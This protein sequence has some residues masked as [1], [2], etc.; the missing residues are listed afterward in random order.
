MNL[1]EL[2]CEYCLATEK[3]KDLKKWFEFVDEFW[4]KHDTCMDFRYIYSTKM[5]KLKGGELNI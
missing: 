4:A 2:Q 1:D 5:R 3:C